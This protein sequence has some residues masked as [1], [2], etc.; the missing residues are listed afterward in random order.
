MDVPDIR[1]IAHNRLYCIRKPPHIIGFN[2]GP[3][4]PDEPIYPDLPDQNM[5]Q[6][7]LD[8]SLP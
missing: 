7:S 2:H 3:R 8:N 6:H 5:G 4:F 1:S